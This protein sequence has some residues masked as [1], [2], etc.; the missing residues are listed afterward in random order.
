MR[1]SRLDVWGTATGPVRSLTPRIRVICG[2]LLFAVCMI[3]PPDR[4]SA[5]ALVLSGLVVW[6]AL[7][8]PPGQVLRA[9]ILFGLILFLPYFLLVP[10]IRVQSHGLG[11]LRAFAVAW[12][13]VFR[14]LSGM[15]ATT[16][17]ATALTEADLREALFRLP[18][19]RYLS[20]LVIQIVHQTGSLLHE[21]RRI[22][23][24]VSVRGGTTN[25]LVGL[26]VLVAIPRAW[27]PRIVDRA[28]RVGDAMDLRGYCEQGPI[29]MGS[30]DETLKDGLALGAGLAFL[31]AAV[32]LL[33]QGGV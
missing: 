8:R 15:T 1:E 28:E 27:F 33:I 18:V 25:R 13:V 31:A 16:I 6:T 23:S 17:T 14:G 32:W 24:A 5:A 29:G 7:V 19:P 26:R 10:L 4:P 12:R 22:V 9:T 21:A 20:S 30:T 11:W 2:I 3:A